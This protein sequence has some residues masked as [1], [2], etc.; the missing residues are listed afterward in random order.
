MS[1]ISFLTHEEVCQLTGARQ[2]AGQIKALIRNGIRHT[3]K[4]NGWPCVTTAAIIG[5]PEQRVMR[6]KWQPRKAS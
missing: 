2:K 3:I 6:E 1:E 5:S 4:R